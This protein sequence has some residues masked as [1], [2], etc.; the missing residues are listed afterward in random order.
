MAFELSVDGEVVANNEVPSESANETLVYMT[1]AWIPEGPGRYELS[2]R[3]MDGAGAYGPSASV[4]I[5]VGEAVQ[6]QPTPTLIGITPIPF[7]TATEQMACIFEAAVNLFCRRGPGNGYSDTD[8]FTPGMTAPVVGESGDGNY[9]YVLGP[10]T[11]RACT[12][13]KGERF[14]SIS[15]ACSPQ[16]R[17]TPPPL[18]PT[19]V[20]STGVPPTEAPSDDDGPGL[21]GTVA[22]SPTPIPPPS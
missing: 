12:V 8:S 16:P 22:P 17:F 14:G 11:G 9:W 4:F 20:P 18:P 5:T 3:A 13:P 21:F 1:Q 15:G 6:L 7:P 19:E 2:V 10:N